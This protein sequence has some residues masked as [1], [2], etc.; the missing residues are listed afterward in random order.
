M[1][2]RQDFKTIPEQISL[3]INSLIDIFKNPKSLIKDNPYFY[4]TLY[5]NQ[6]IIHLYLFKLIIN[7]KEYIE[8]K[9]N[10]YITKY[11]KKIYYKIY[12]ITNIEYNKELDLIVKIKEKLTLDSYTY[13]ENRNRIIFKD[14][15]YVDARWLLTFISMI[16]DNAKKDE[17]KEINICYTI[18]NRDIK[19]VKEDNIEDFLKEFT[20]Y[21]IKVKH[22]DTTKPVR[23]N[24]ILIVKNAAINYLKHL[25]QYRHGLETSESY[26]I[27]YNLLK[28]ECQKEGFELQE[29]ETNLLDINP[30]ELAKIEVLFNEDYYNLPLSKQVQIIEN[31]IWQKSNDIT[32]LENINSSIDSIIDF[33]TIIRLENNQTFEDINQKYEINFI[34]IIMILSINLFLVT[35][36]NKD[37]FDY[38]LLD[39]DNA[40][41]KYMNNICENEEQELKS[42]LK[43]LN[44]ELQS[45]KKDLEEYKVERNVLNT[46]ELPPDKYQKELERCVGNI[47]RASIQIGRLN[48]K[49]ASL[50]KEY[51]VIRKEL[52][53]KYHNVDLYNYNSSIIKHI[54]NSILSCAFYLKTNNTSSVFN[55]VIIFEDYEKTENSF[56]LELTFKELLKISNQNILNGLL[57]Q[58]DL[59][60]LA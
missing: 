51:E 47:N 17:N 26:L 37:S 12:G 3:I 52:E 33:L 54:I 11:P 27:F 40:K 44:L 28:R 36:L 45:V 13:D 43:K 10:E 58:Q 1:I 16:L 20:Y 55:N 24:H 32:L 39:F 60:K 5:K 7:D 50:S 25:K 38:S 22:I 9:Y 18:P 19:K 41:P 31:T 21:N 2:V 56:Y 53:T 42:K 8:H 30:R 15:T 4:H 48:S 29:T 59:P 35:Y 6:F 23:E 49:I 46:N 57:E 14:N 34:P